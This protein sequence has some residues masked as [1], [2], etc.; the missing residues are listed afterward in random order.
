MKVIF[1]RKGFDSAAGGMPSPIL[2]DG[3]LLSLPIPSSKD[4]VQYGDLSYG[5]MS[6]NEIIRELS[7]RTQLLA[8]STCHLDPDIRKGVIH[9]VKW[10]PAFGQVG[11][12]LSHLDKQGVGVGDLFLFFGWYRQTE[13][14][15]GRL[16]YVPNAPDL[17]IFYGYLQIG[18]IIRDKKDIPSELL[19]HPHA[20]D[21]RWT[22][23][24][25]ALFLPTEIL[26]L[27]TNLP[28]YACLCYSPN[29]VLTKSG[30]KRRV[31]NLPPFFR[32][33]PISY[34]RTAWKEDGFYSA[35][36][37]QEFVFEANDKVLEWVKS[38][39]RNTSDKTL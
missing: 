35:G 36:R 5:G 15:N 4:S 9:R 20:A 7:P 32:E 2:P 24:K 31:W 10:K 29:R 8:S 28:G 19:I 3:T 23:G 18:S 39:I 17:H 14:H 12:S 11:A 33:I 21:F 37:G 16:R 26:S 27:D 22:N 30:C 25:N 6:Y 38:I 34:N 13:F 1:S